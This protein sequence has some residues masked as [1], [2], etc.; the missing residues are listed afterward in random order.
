MRLQSRS[1]G[2]PTRLPMED[3]LNQLMQLTQQSRFDFQRALEAPFALSEDDW[4]QLHAA[5]IGSRH[6][7]YMFPLLILLTSLGVNMANWENPGGTYENEVRS[8][9]K[10]THDLRMEIIKQQD[11]LIFPV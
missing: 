11:A 4:K 10:W 9:L 8:Y 5:I 2:L 3:Y 6:T 1:A 7:H